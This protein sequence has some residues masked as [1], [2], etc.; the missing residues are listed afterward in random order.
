MTIDDSVLTSVGERVVSSTD[1]VSGYYVDRDDSTLAFS[2]SPLSSRDVSK[3]RREAKGYIKQNS[4]TEPL[5]TDVGLFSTIGGGSMPEF[6][7]ELR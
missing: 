3:I 5:D 6:A 1:G 4:G 7:F 2:V